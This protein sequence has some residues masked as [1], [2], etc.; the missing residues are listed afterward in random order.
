MLSGF[1]LRVGA[2]LPDPALLARAGATVQVC[3]DPRD[4]VAGAN[5]VYAGSTLTVGSRP[6][7]AEQ[8]ANLLPITQAVLRALVTGDWEV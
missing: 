7:D 4:A 6:L 1:E 3:E 8:T 2:P 5:A